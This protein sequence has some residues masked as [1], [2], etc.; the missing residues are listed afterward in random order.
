[1]RNFVQEGQTLTLTAP[2]TVTSGEGVIVGGIFSVA[3][4]DA[5]SGAAFEGLTEGVFDFP[6]TAAVTPAQG[7]AAFFN[8]TTKAVTGTSATGLFKIGVF[9]KTAAGGDATARVRLDGVGV[10]AV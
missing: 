5:A 6:K 3:Q 8:N 4:A 7:A 1:M 10:V 2:E 9:T